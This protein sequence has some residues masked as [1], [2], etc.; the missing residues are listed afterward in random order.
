MNRKFR[1]GCAHRKSLSRLMYELV[2]RKEIMTVH[3][4]VGIKEDSGRV[5]VGRKEIMTVHELVGLKENYELVGRKEIM[6]WHKLVG[7]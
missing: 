6:T 2:G 5:M 3:K 1:F 7:L 4:L